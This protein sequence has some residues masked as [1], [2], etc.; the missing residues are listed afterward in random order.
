M[1]KLDIDSVEHTLTWGEV[2]ETVLLLYLSVAQIEI[3]MSDGDKS[4]NTLVDSFTSMSGSIRII[5]NAAAEIDFTE[6]AGKKIKELRD[7]ITLNSAIVAHRM[8]E[9]IIAFQFYDKLSQRL[10]HVSLS[11]SELAELVSDA[12]R[13]YQKQEWLY[14]QQ[15]IKAVYS[16]IEETELFDAII[17]GVTVD[18]AIAMVYAKMQA[19]KEN[20]TEEVDDDDDIELF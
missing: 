8:Q 19:A 7:T 15:K 20:V 14:L 6:D 11:L 2:R 12:D 9:S 3:S 1:S 17:A 16:M 10:L 4:V 18:D 13:L 5:E